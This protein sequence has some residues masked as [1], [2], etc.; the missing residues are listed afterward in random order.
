MRDLDS[1]K[2]AA[3]CTRSNECKY[4]CSCNIQY[5]YTVQLNSYYSVFTTVKDSRWTLRLDEQ[6][7]KHTSSIH[8]FLYSL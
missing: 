1:E 8:N 2:L 6:L 5:S 4:G 7:F 3:G